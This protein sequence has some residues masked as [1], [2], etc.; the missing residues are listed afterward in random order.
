[1][2]IK[3]WDNENYEYPL[4]EIR[5]DSIEVLKSILKEYQSDEEYNWDDFL[6]LLTKRGLMY[7]V[8]D[9]DPD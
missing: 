5:E 8:I 6:Y 3:F 2:I 4:L 9:T 7:K 1:M